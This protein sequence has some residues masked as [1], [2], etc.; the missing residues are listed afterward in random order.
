MNKNTKTLTQYLHTSLSNTSSLKNH[1]FLTSQTTGDWKGFMDTIKWINSCTPPTPSKSEF[2]FELSQATAKHNSSI[3][4]KYNFNLSTAIEANPNSILSPGSELRPLSQLSLLLSHHKN[5]KH[6]KESI[7]KGID[8][9][10]KDLP[11]K[12]RKK[13]LLNQLLRGNHKSALTKEASPVVDK[14]VKQDVELGFAIP[15]TKEC[16]IKLKGGELYP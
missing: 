12:L 7:T 14:L 5:F 6:L 16:M 11:E 4:R 1:P 3:L 9:P 2:N 15:I 10:A 8:Y 13:E